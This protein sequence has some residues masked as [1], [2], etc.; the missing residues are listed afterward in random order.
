V[1]IGII[2][3]GFIARAVTAVAT[4]HGHEIMVSNTR[5]P[6]TLFSRTGCTGCKAGSPQEAAEVGDI[7]QE[8]LS[9]SLK[10]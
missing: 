6:E 1:K 9:H 3:A 5:G 2:G 4:K 7:V 8:A 10:E